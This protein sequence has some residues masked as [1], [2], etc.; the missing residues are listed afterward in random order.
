M[1]EYFREVVAPMGG[2][3]VTAN[4]EYYAAGLLAGDRRYVVPAIHDPSYVPTLLRIVYDEKISMVLSLFDVDLPILAATRA[5]FKQHGAEVAVSDPDVIETAGDKWK[6]YH[7][8]VSNDIST[9]RTWIDIDLA[10]RAVHDGETHFPLIIKPRWGMGS[11]GVRRV[12]SVDHIH[13]AHACLSVEI[14][15]SYL[16]LMTKDPQ[17]IIIQECIEGTEYGADVLNDVHCNYL[18]TAVR[19]KIA[20]R[21]GETDVAVTVSDPDIEGCCRKLSHLLKHRG[22]MDIDLI[23]TPSGSLYVLDLNPRFGGGYPFSHSAGARYPRA[24][25]QSLLGVEPQPG[26][27][28]YGVYCLKD[29][30]LDRILPN[31]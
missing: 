12:Y 27:M 29:I 8:L 25:V 22:N 3:V 20:M 15:R 5:L 13:H 4:S 30:Q 21:S 10:I 1:V 14:E 31:G 28:E 17:S 16:S 19:R 26:D 6:M 18:A 7:Y 9:P 11:I 23:K 2:L 24:L